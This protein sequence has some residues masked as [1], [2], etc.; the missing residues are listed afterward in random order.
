VGVGLA[1]SEGGARDFPVNE[2][3]QP[4]TALPGAAYFDSAAYFGMIRGG[5]VDAAI[6]GGLQVDAHANLANWAIP[7]K[8]LLGVGGA[9]DL[10]ANTRRLIIT[11]THTSRKGVS[12]IVPEITLPA[13]S[14]G[15]VDAIITELA[16]FR[17]IEGVLTLTELMP[18]VTLDEVQSKT[19]APFE[20]ALG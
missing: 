19:T 3:K 17:F 4:G 5:H 15:T 10:A 6:M 2:G 7:G 13:T 1:P 11:M 16:V 20:V 8:P 9:M 12:K 14:L 18:G